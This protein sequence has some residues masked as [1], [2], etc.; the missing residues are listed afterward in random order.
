[1][2]RTALLLAG[3]TLFFNPLPG[4]GVP[5]AHAQMDWL[6]PKLESQRYDNTRRHQQRL[7]TYRQRPQSSRPGISPARM[8]QLM[9]QVE[10]EYRRRVQI[11][12]KAR[13]DEWLKRTAYRLGVEEGRRAR[14][15]L[16]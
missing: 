15:N 3:L 11:H 13:A 8:R 5:S 16:R 1:M 2:K 12:G 10:P 4:A 9:R 6:T 14:R 7:G